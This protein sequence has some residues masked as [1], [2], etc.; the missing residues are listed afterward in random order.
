VPLLLEELLSP[1]EFPRVRPYRDYLGWLDKQDR[2]SAERAW[3]D[4]LYGLEGP[5]RL[6]SAP[7]SA[8]VFPQTVDVDLPEHLTSALTA[9][10][11]THGFTSIR[12]FKQP[13]GLF[14]RRFRDVGKSCLDHR[15]GASG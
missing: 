2:A 3:R 13:G 11:R 9:A 6:A 10:A 8:R 14:W 4:A 1:R 12:C 5:T 15:V 7:A